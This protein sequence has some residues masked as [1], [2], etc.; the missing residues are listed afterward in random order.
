MRETG[1][2]GHRGGGVALMVLPTR[3]LGFRSL[4][5]LIGGVRKIQA[6]LY[7]WPLLQQEG[8]KNKSQVLLLAGSLYGVGPGVGREWWLRR[9][10][11]PLG[12]AVKGFGLF[13]S[14]CL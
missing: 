1:E 13:V 7:W 3:D 14:C 11:H 10:A 5:K 9:S 12:G 2:D 8:A 4:Q 6:R